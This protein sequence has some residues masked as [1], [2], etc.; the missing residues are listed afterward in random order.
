M[1]CSGDA[2]R[3]PPEGGSVLFE[4]DAAS[5]LLQ[6]GGGHEACVAGADDHTVEVPRSGVRCR[7]AASPLV[8]AQ[9]PTAS[10][11]FMTAAIVSFSCSVL[12]NSTTSVPA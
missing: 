1:S 12:V 9:L 7:Q 11:F 6:E 4:D 3:P 8:R 2:T 10:M 5:C